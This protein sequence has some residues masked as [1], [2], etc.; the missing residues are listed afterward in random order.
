MMDSK[1]LKQKIKTCLSQE[2]I[3]NQINEIYDTTFIELDFRDTNERIDDLK[4]QIMDDLVH[5][6][7]L[8]VDNLVHFDQIFKE[9]EDEIISQVKVIRQIQD[10]YEAFSSESLRKTNMSTFMAF[11]AVVLFLLTIVGGIII[12]VLSTLESRKQYK[13]K[14]QN[15]SYIASNLNISLFE[16]RKN[17]QYLYNEFGLYDQNTTNQ[18]NEY[19]KNINIT[20][21]EMNMK[22][23]E[24]EL[25]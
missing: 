4:S 2:E 20:F 19:I 1:E 23:N 25:V 15:L 16:Y 9:L 18:I 8:T 12:M 17:S 5:T 24:L 21:K 13:L 7:K 22:Q 10:E 14:Q 6:Q 11:S 3:R